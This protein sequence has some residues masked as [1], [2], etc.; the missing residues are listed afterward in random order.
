[1]QNATTASINKRQGINARF[2]YPPSFA[3]LLLV[4]ERS[5]LHE[6]AESDEEELGWPWNMTATSYSTDAKGRYVL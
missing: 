4:F 3:T 2:I 6:H 5:C 1:M